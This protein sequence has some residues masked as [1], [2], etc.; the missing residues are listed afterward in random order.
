MNLLKHIANI[1]ALWTIPYIFVLFFMLITAFAFTYEEAV[2][3]APFI[4][5][6]TI[7]YIMSLLMYFVLS[8]EP[9]FHKLQLFKTSKWVD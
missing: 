2:T 5:I 6:S 9:E 3:S 1:L 7:Y 8:D 4:I